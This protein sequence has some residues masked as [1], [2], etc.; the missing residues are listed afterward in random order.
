MTKYIANVN[1]P[2]PREYYKPNTEKVFIRAGETFEIEE[3]YAT[4]NL[5]AFGVIDKVGARYPEQE[6]KKANLPEN[7]IDCRQERVSQVIMEAQ[8]NSKKNNKIKN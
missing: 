3:S 6:I 5:E 7:Y 2:D 8:I 1:L 4:Q